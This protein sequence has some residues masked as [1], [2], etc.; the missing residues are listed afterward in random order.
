MDDVRANQQRLLVNLA[1]HR[2]RASSIVLDGHFC[3][4]N[5]DLEIEEIPVAVF[6]QI[7][8]SLL[9]LI[10]IA[11]AIAIERLTTREQASFDVARLSSLASREETH[12]RAVSIALSVPLE[13]VREGV[14]IAATRDRISELMRP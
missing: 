5:R 1:Q 4:Y 9:L 7:Q 10:E 13:I 8:P 2:E 11:P 12:A 3:V 6:F 14:L